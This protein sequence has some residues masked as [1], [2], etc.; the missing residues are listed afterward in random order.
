MRNL[1]S[2]YQLKSTSTEIEIDFFL[3]KIIL[4]VSRAILRILL[5]ISKK[6]KPT[7][8]IE[9]KTFWSMLLFYLNVTINGTQWGYQ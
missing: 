6:R 8:K 1:I 2:S 3:L 4:A 9:I 5:D 7:I